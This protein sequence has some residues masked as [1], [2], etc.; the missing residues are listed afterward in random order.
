MI[1]GF[2][3]VRHVGAQQSVGASQ[4]V[5]PSREQA[6]PSP[7]RN[8]EDPDEVF[9]AQRPKLSPRPRSQGPAA[10]RN[11]LWNDVEVGP[12]PSRGYMGS[13]PK[14]QTTRAASSGPRPGRSEATHANSEDRRAPAVW[15]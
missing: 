8:G 7:E 13:S 3:A 5:L 2:N 10:P 12:R 9:A 1:Q 6:Q 11:Q 4:G 14:A 15:E